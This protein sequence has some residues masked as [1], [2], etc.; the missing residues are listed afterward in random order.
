VIGS[1]LMRAPFSTYFPA[2]SALVA[3]TLTCFPTTVAAAATVY[4]S[5]TEGLDLRRVQLIVVA[6]D[7]LKE[8]L[9]DRALKLFAE[10]GLPSPGS[11]S[12]K[13]PP[14]AVLT[15]TLDPR[16]IDS[17]CP[18]KVLY[19]PSLVLTEPV[20]IARAGS[21]IQDTTWLFETGREV[22]E[23]VDDERITADLDRFI[24][25]FIADYQTANRQPGEQQTARTVEGE[26]PFSIEPGNPNRHTALGLRTI[27]M[28]SLSVMA[29]QW[30]SVLKASAIRQLTEAG[31]RL[32]PDTGE[33]GVVSLSLELTQRT[34][35]D[36]CRGKVLYERGLY[37][38]EQIRITRRPLVTLWSDIWLQESVQIVP[39]LSLEELEVDQRLLLQRFLRSHETK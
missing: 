11:H 22:R 29:G 21:T 7:K 35:G 30:S 1:H 12:S 25:Q 20:T 37:L 28:L 13:A 34:I 15:L 24:G 9:H 10:A 23:P 19:A 36:Q 17:V 16:P 4:M 8:A 2:T 5:S 31:L 32:V 6:P 18:G 26:P 39:P 38:V 14:S 33:D 3:L 27:P